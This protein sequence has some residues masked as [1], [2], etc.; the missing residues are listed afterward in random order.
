MHYDNI[1]GSCNTA[2][3]RDAASHGETNSNEMAKEELS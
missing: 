3:S 2:N 1:K